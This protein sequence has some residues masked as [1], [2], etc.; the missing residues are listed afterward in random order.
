MFPTNQSDHI[1]HISHPHHHCRT[2]QFPS[3]SGLPHPIISTVASPRSSSNLR[4]QRPSRA[5]PIGKEIFFGYKELRSCYGLPMAVPFFQTHLYQHPDVYDTETPKVSSWTEYDIETQ[6]QKWTGKTVDVQLVLGRLPLQPRPAR[7][8]LEIWLKWFLVHSHLTMKNHGHIISYHL[9][10]ST[11]TS[12]SQCFKVRSKESNK[13]HTWIGFKER[14]QETIVTL[15]Y[16]KK[17]LPWFQLTPSQSVTRSQVAIPGIWR[18]RAWSLKP[19]KVGK[20]SAA[21]AQDIY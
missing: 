6:Y 9:P 7:A 2:A 12:K 13:D 20:L 8:F 18:L 5:E 14:L 19:V 21:I 1:P 11:L 4:K 17:N 15:N 10:L 16:P 3:R